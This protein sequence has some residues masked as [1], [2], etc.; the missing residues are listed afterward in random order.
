MAKPKRIDCSREEAAI[1]EAKRRCGIDDD[2]I[3]FHGINPYCYNFMLPLGV[4]DG[5]AAAFAN[6]VFHAV[7][8]L[9]AGDNVGID[10][11]NDFCK[12]IRD[13][14]RECYAVIFNHHLV[15]EDDEL[16]EYSVKVLLEDEEDDDDD[17]AGEYMRQ[18]ANGIK[19]GIFRSKSGEGFFVLKEKFYD[20][21]ASGRK[22]T[23]Y[24]D[25]TPRNLNCSIGIKTVRLR[26]A[27]TKVEMR[28]E[29]AS[30]ALM[31]ADDR[32]CDPFNI[33]P[34]FVA[35]TIAIHLGKRIG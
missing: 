19:S 3:G 34:D 15:A 16:Y 24:R 1:E 14:E 33:P 12:L 27:Y 20:E 32:E 10:W 21:I 2:D 31:D 29:V 17:D 23:E 25:I 11:G 30:V 28:F 13:D 18:L 6:C 7:G 9:D 26:R 5:R 35:T 22:T 4:G 8:V